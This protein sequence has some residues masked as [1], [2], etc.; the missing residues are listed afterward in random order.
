LP[1]LQD[2]WWE[3]A[4]K[5]FEITLPAEM[6]QDLSALFTRVY[7]QSDDEEESKT[8]RSKKPSWVRSDESLSP[9]NNKGQD[10]TF[11]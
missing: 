1:K 9:L 8:S 7:D 3:Q 11:S 10:R 4:L 5:K 2:K 6:Q